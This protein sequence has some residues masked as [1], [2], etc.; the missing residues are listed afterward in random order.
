MAFPSQRIHWGA[1]KQADKPSGVYPQ[2]DSQRQPGN[3]QTTGRVY[4][5]GPIDTS[6]ILPSLPERALVRFKYNLGELIWNTAALE[7]NAFTLPEVITLLDGV[8][9]GGRSIEDEE[10]ILALSEGYNFVADHVAAGTFALTREFS[11]QVHALVA[12]H[13]AIESGLFRGQGVVSGGGTVRLSQGGLVEGDEHGEKGEKLVTDYLNLLASLSQI[14]D[15]RERA[16]A[17]FC[18]AV[19]SQFYFDGNKR[20][21]RLMMAGELMSHGFDAIN[22]PFA[23]RLEFNQALD[24]LF[25]S[26]DATQLMRFL[27]SCSSRPS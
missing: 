20:T 4:W 13:E 23:R 10:Q 14:E 8:T 5:R 1:G 22:I 26:D 17:Y 16:L 25:M 7:G 11:N 27:V 24:V 6:P 15:P 3:Q 2:V 18:S 12:R 21:A 19:R 9:V